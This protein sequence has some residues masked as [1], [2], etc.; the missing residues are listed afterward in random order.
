MLIT[1][2]GNGKSQ[3]LNEN[4]IDGK[5]LIVETSD[6]AFPKQILKSNAM[7]II[8]D[9]LEFLDSLTKDY[10]TDEHYPFMVNKVLFWGCAEL[11]KLKNF[12]SN[13]KDF[14]PEFS[15]AVAIHK[16]NEELSIVEMCDF[17]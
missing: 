4:F 7:Y 5:T 14:H 16:D 12:E 6:I 15:V 10:L 9:R 13:I 2:G 3:W 1:K 11:F 8:E 17:I